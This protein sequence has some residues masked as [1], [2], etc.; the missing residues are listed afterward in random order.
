MASDN[1]FLDLNDKTISMS[2][3]FLLRQRFFSVVQLGERPF[4]AATGPPQFSFM[5][6]VPFFASNVVISDGQLGVSS[7]MGIHGVENSNIWINH[8]HIRDFETGGIQLNG[9]R[10]VH[11]TNV[12]IGPSLGHPNSVARVPGLATLSQA[13][14]LLRIVDGEFIE[15]EDVAFEQLRTSVESYISQ[16]LAGGSIAESERVFAN[17]DGIPDG[18]SLYGIVLHAAKP[19]IHDFASC[20]Q[21]DGEEDGHSFGPASLK[22]VT[23]RD[24][25]LKTDEVVSMQAGGSPVM[26]PA[27]DVMQIF[28]IQDEN[29]NYVGNPLSEAQLALGRLRLAHTGESEDEI[30]RLYGATNIPSEFVAWTEHTMTWDSM[31]S[32][33]GGQFV[34][35]K[36]AMTH[37]NKGVMGVRVE[38]YHD[39]SYDNVRVEGFENVGRASDISHCT[40]DDYA[41][42][43]NDARGFTMSYVS[44]ISAEHVTVRGMASPRGFAYGVED[45]EEVSYE[46][47]PYYDIEGV[48]G[49][50]GS[51]TH[52][53]GTNGMLGSDSQ[54]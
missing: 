19:A 9:A 25:L 45:R 5:D 40:G 46:S 18:S 8:V 49:L 42:S 30:F 51:V 34:C 20:P 13:L 15:N 43:G 53:D 27:G 50:L 32:A 23:V 3:E 1:V 2:P 31:I 44:G 7:H 6:K 22:D 17:D 14:L 16:V 35:M 37:H 10:D 39:V 21:F 11:I 38:Y 47:T 48:Q 24:L 12:E 26:G 36:D 29:G 28:R 41:Y 33:V 54:Y 4:K 52:D